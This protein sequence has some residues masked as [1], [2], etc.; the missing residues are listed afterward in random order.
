MHGRKSEE[1]CRHG[2]HGECASDDGKDLRDE[3][4]PPSVA[5]R[6]HHLHR[7]E[8]VGELSLWDRVPLERADAPLVRL[9]VAPETRGLE[10]C[11]HH[12]DEVVRSLV[13][14]VDGETPPIQRVDLPPVLAR[15]HVY[16]PPRCL[17]EREVVHG[18]RDVS[19]GQ[20]QRLLVR[21][22][23]LEVYGAG[24]P[25]NLHVTGDPAALTENLVVLGACV[26]VAL[27]DLSVHEGGQGLDLPRTVVLGELLLPRATPV[28]PDCGEALHALIRASLL[29]VNAVDLEHADVCCHMVSVHG[30]VLAVVHPGLEIIPGWPKLSAMW[31]PIRVEVHHGDVVR[32][33]DSLEVIVLE[34]VAGGAPISVKLGKLLFR[35]ALVG[36][37]QLHKL[38]LVVG[39]PLRVTLVVDALLHDIAR[40]VHTLRSEG[41]PNTHGHE[42]ASHVKHV[43]VEVDAEGGI[44]V[45]VNDNACRRLGGHEGAGLAEEEHRADDDRHHGHHGTRDCGLR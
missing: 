17:S 41:I 24:H 34:V 14:L 20:V 26:H 32:V 13:E 23:G 6:D 25:G 1:P 15:Q 27:A 19:E 11:V 7:R 38:V 42:V 10:T 39:M 8:I 16:R 3:V 45:A 28:Q 40:D 35:E 2:H 29:E 36:E 30:L 44:L 22:H 18:V 33:N 9:L 5:L 4:I 31:A 21:V 12:L 37:L 43:H